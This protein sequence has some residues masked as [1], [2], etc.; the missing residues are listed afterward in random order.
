VE[1]TTETTAFLKQKGLTFVDVDRPAYRKA[2]QG[3]YT[4]FRS[5][6]GPDLFDTVIKQVE[7][8]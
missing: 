7:S 2:T 1:K 3:V 8:A 6:I 5:I 4:Q